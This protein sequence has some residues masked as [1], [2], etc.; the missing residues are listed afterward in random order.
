MK[1]KIIK[2]GIVI[3]IALLL[4]PIPLAYKDG[5]TKSYNAVLYKIIVW[6][7]LD[8]NEPGGYRTGTDFYIFPFNFVS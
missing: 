2:I 4:I 1:R 6:N 8:E 5:G 7:A 3:L